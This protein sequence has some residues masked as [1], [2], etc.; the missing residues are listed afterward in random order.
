M[1]WRAEQQALLTCI[2]GSLCN[3]GVL[4]SFHPF[5]RCQEDPP[6]QDHHC[7]LAMILPKS[8]YVVPYCLLYLKN[9]PPIY[10]SCKIKIKF[11]SLFRNRSILTVWTG[12][13]LVDTIVPH[14]QSYLGINLFPQSY[15]CYLFKT[16]PL[17]IQPAMACRSLARR[18]VLAACQ[19]SQRFAVCAE[20]A[21]AGAC[22]STRSI[23]RSVFSS[24]QGAN[25]GE[26]SHSTVIPRTSCCCVWLILF[27]L[28][29]HPRLF[30]AFQN[31]ILP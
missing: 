26:P 16:I 11:L 13:S 1:V 28:S 5:G 29:L 24:I 30:C 27:D 10:N 23:P 31:L 19:V 7:C 9:N 20:S 22:T 12:K 21:S 2:L 25:V 18:A 8:L 14:L 17:L 4:A 6:N 15:I 3:L